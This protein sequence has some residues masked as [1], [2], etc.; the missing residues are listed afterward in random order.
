MNTSKRY[1]VCR[2][3]ILIIAAM[4][5]IPITAILAFNRNTPALVF[6]GPVIVGVLKPVIS[7]IQNTDAKKRG[8]EVPYTNWYEWF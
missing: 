8:W 6:V 5:S 2:L 1:K 3:V 7:M 4:I